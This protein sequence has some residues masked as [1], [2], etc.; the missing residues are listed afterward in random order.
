MKLDGCLAI[1]TGG[2]SGIGRAVTELLL[3]HGGKVSY[4][5]STH[6]QQHR[7]FFSFTG[8]LA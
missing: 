2:V 4:Q 5:Y 6:I 3:Q 8:H 7:P 1:V